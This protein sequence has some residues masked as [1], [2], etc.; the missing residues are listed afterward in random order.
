VVVMVV[1]VVVPR[2]VVR[3]GRRLEEL[4]DLRR[5]L[6][7]RFDLELRSFC[8]CRR[9]LK[10]LESLQLLLAQVRV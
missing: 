3:R 5:R 1:Q 2:G 4:V 10:A 7:T 9:L 6:A 8:S